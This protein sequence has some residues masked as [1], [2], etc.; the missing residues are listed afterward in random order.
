MVCDEQIVRIKALVEKQCIVCG[1][2]GLLVGTAIAKALRN[3]M[4]RTEEYCIVV[5]VLVREGV[6]GW[7]LLL[8]R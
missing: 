7:M 2:D 1:Q 8:L 5:Y 6:E 3:A 4:I